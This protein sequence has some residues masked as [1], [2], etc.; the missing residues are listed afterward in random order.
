MKKSFPRS[1]SLVTS[2]TADKKLKTTQ[3]VLKTN[4]WLDYCAQEDYMVREVNSAGTMIAY[5]HS[6]TVVG[7]WISETDIESNGVDYGWIFLTINQTNS[8]N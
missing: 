4:E 2:L 7:K 5:S 8:V 1:R 3:V 6:R